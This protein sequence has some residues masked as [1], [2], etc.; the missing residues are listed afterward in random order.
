MGLGQRPAQSRGFHTQVLENESVKATWCSQLLPG[1]QCR[2]P[3]GST[4]AVSCL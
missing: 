1:P 2:R 4:I 3:P